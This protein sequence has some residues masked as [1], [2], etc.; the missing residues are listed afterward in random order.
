MSPLVAGILAGCTTLLA[1]GAVVSLLAARTRTRVLARLGGSAEAPA[2]TAPV[3]FSDRL[4]EIVPTA[5]APTWWLH[6]RIVLGVV[7]VAALLSAPTPLVMAIGIGGVVTI[8]RRR[9]GSTASDESDA[10]VLAERLASA[11]ASGSDPTRTVVSLLGPEADSEIRRALDDGEPLQT[12]ID[13]WAEA[14]ADP[15]R[16]LLADAWAVA[17]TTGAGIA[18]ALLRTTRTLRDRVAVDREITALTA[19]AR[20]SARVLTILPMGFAALVAMVD[21]RVRDLLLHTTAGR[22]GI[23]LGLLLDWIGARWMNHLVEASR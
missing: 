5:D 6:T 22:L 19:Q 2:A 20:L 11:L 13:R 15:D 23:A 1:T 7:T 3:W 9:A 8:L 17:G 12:A 14:D 18:P 4:R 21:H 10:A 16:R